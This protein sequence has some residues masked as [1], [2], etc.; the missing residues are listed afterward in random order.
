MSMAR[1]C[2]Q[3]SGA[4][5][6]EAGRSSSPRCVSTGTRETTQAL[7]TDL[8]EVDVAELPLTE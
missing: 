7:E 8:D 6:F 3:S 1:H 2:F 4:T 5:Q